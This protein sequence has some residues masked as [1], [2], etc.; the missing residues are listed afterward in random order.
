MHRSTTDWKHC[1]D[2]RSAV[3]TTGANAGTVLDLT[4]PSTYRVTGLKP[5]AALPTPAGAAFTLATTATGRL[6][7]R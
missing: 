7:R 4:N 6:V 5:L 3:L 2:G 1:R